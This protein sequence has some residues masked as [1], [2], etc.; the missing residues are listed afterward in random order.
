MN[1]VLLKEYLNGSFKAEGFYFNREE[2]EIIFDENNPNVQCTNLIFSQ[3][4]G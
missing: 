3:T 1:I 2:S 4:A